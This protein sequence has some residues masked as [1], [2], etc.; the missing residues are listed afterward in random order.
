MTSSRLQVF[1][2]LPEFQSFRALPSMKTW[3]LVP[4]MG[5]LHAGHA[6]LLK[7]ARKDCDSV[8]LTIFVNPTQFNNPN[9]L[10]TYPV[11]WEADLKV[12]QDCGV[13][14]VLAPRAEEMYPDK[15]TYQMHETQFST[16]LCGTDRVGHFDGVLSVVLKFFNLVQPD[17]A[18]FG[19]KDFQQLSLIQGLKQAY[20]LP[21]EIIPVPTVRESD[22]LAMSSRNLR[23]TPEE[24]KLAPHLHRV[25]QASPSLEEARSELNSL[26]FKVVYLE[27]MRGRRLV[28]AFLGN[29]RLIDNI[30]WLGTET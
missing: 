19:E 13:D 26:G 30:P 25:L 9:D 21:L 28:A 7:R 27:E 29:V 14:I 22:G 17:R 24:R 1:R 11:T 5:A 16:Q 2:S 3:G 4:T 8:V 12:A 18:Y 20:F 6:E 23:L 10:Q 15:Y